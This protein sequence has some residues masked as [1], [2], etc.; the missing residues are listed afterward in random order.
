VNLVFGGALRTWHATLRIVITAAATGIAAILHGQQLQTRPVSQPAEPPIEE[1]RAIAAPA[2]PLVSEKDSRR[3]KKVSFIVYGD[4]RGGATTDGVMLHAVHSRLMD[5][6]IEVVRERA[7][8]SRAIRFVLQTGD[9][10]LRGGDARMWNVSFTPVIDRLTRDAGVPYFLTPGNH[11]V[12][13]ARNANPSSGRDNTLRAIGHLLPPPGSDRRH[14]ASLTYAFGIGHVY[15]VSIDSNIASDPDQFRWVSDQL[16][17]LDRKRFQTVVAFMHHPPYSSGPH[18]VPAGVEPQTLAVRSIWMPLFRRHQVRL[19]L[20]GHEHVFEHWIERY[21]ERSRAHRMDVVITGGGGAPITAY[22]GEPD[23]SAY[24]ANAA[25]QSVS[26]EHV[27]KPR[28]T[29][30]GNPHH[31][32]VID[33]DGKKIRQEIVAL[34]DA[35]FAPFNGRTHQPLHD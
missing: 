27:A 31:F 19:V 28:P 4:T 34:D 26:V 7:T 16:D 14:G 24:L 15:V 20:A 25:P 5:R 3:L 17:R 35:S 10:V 9:A 33:V 18:G 30:A 8:T 29:V 32:V 13:A 2:R 21:T 23:L 22:R 12:L 1:V 11:D 6:M